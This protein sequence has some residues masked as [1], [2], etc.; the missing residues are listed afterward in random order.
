[1]SHAKGA[2][3]AKGEQQSDEGKALIPERQTAEDA[4]YAKYGRRDLVNF[5]LLK[6]LENP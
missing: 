3:A 5:Y 1:M 4:K 6:T 2:K